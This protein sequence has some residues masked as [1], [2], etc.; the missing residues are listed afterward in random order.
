M[1][2]AEG[3]KASAV[4][5]ALTLFP[6]FPQM[7]EKKVGKPARTTCTVISGLTPKGPPDQRGTV[8]RHRHTTG[9]VG[10]V[11]AGGGT[12]SDGILICDRRGS[13]SGALINPPQMRCHEAVEL[14][15]SPVKPEIEITRAA[16]RAAASAERCASSLTRYKP[17]TSMERAAMAMMATMATA[18]STMVTP[19]SRRA[20]SALREFRDCGRFHAVF[21]SRSL[22]QRLR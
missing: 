15:G 14:P 13:L 19:R 16:A 3:L 12:P 17:I 4:A 21:S 5:V 11:D 18:T 7:R 6:V 22:P 9:R 2:D 20:R 1:S 10:H 8:V